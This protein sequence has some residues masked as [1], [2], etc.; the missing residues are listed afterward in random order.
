MT[1]VLGIV[2][3][4]NQQGR[5]GGPISAYD[6]LA[7]LTVPSGGVTS[8]TFAGV[9]AGYKHLQVRLISRDTGSNAGQAP[10]WL[11]FNNDSTNSY[12]WHRIYGTGNGSTASDSGTTT[13]WIL[14]GIGAESTN[15]ANNFST[16]IFDIL[17]YASVT[18]NKTLRS[19]SGEDVNGPG[20]YIGFHSGLWQKTSAITTMT[21]FPN[22]GQSF[23]ANSNFA[24]YGVK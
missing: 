24:L 7:T 8:V 2:A 20:G 21:I 10:V 4:S 1:P 6:A 17:D 16:T 5:G 11:R 13:D 3:S 23:V 15:P 14:A 12:S 18:K 9:P 22:A 19:F